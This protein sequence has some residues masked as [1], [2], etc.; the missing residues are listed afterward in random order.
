MKKEI[1][2]FRGLLAVAIGTVV[3]VVFARST[4]PK[5]DQLARIDDFELVGYLVFVSLVFWLFGRKTPV[6]PK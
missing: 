6:V 1:D 4:L 3:L 2:W 5:V